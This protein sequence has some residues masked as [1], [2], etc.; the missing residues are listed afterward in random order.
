M[1]RLILGKDQDIVKVNGHFS[2]SDK[3]AEDVVHH[4]LER[5]RQIGEPKEHDGGFIQ[6]PVHAEGG[7]LLVASSYLDVVVSP[8]NVELSEVFCP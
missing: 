5:G 8:T 1:F 3:V 2:L 7:L 6:T 4:P